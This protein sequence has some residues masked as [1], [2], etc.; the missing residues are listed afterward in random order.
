MAKKKRYLIV[1]IGIMLLLWTQPAM[2]AEPFSVTADKSEIQNGETFTVTNV[3]Y[4]PEGAALKNLKL[5]AILPEGLYAKT[6]EITFETVASGES[7]TWELPISVGK[8]TALLPG[9]TTGGNPKTGKDSTPIVAA[10]IVVAALLVGAAVSMKDRKKSAKI[11]SLFLVAVISTQSLTG[12]RVSAAEASITEEQ[13][14]EVMVNGQKTPIIIRAEI[15]EAIPT[16]DADIEWR[17]L[18]T[19]DT[20]ATGARFFTVVLN[21]QA[22]FSDKLSPEMITTSGAFENTAIESVERLD[23][24][25]V[26]ISFDAIGQTEDTTAGILAFDASAF[27]DQKAPGY[28]V[29]DVLTPAPY[30]DA[31]VSEVNFN[32]DGSVTLAFCMIQQNFR[33]RLSLSILPLTKKGLSLKRSSSPQQ[34]TVGT[35]LLPSL[36]TVNRIVQNR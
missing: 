31:G 16:S 27:A 24:H 36:L 6:T 12:Y 25:S 22:D 1:L 23:S 2:A 8:D 14:I 9:S 34:K 26:K 17:E 11:L 21:S 18:T 35:A 28:A 10:G 7:V 29:V 3:F 15:E 19:A 30:F 32:A 4:N 13:Q 33:T 20:V 5:T